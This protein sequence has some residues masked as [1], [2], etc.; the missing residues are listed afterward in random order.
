[1]SG[2]PLRLAVVVDAI[3][4]SLD[5]GVQIRAMVSLANGVGDRGQK[6]THFSTAPSLKSSALWPWN[7]FEH[8]R[9]KP[10]FCLKIP[11]LAASPDLLSPLKQR[12]V[13]MVFKD[14]AVSRLT[15]GVV[16]LH[17]VGLQHGDCNVERAAASFQ[18]LLFAGTEAGDFVRSTVIG[19]G[20]DSERR[21]ANNGCAHKAE[22]EGLGLHGD[23][24]E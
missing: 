17:C 16:G 22:E 11:K 2:E 4:A 21:G 5:V 20:F 14:D 1:M 18:D 12:G 3:S 8:S 19:S 7:F 6:A 10:Q 24:V 23:R 9:S 15:I 13:S